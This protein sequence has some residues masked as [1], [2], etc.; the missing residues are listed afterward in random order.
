MRPIDSIASI[1]GTSNRA[2]KFRLALFS[3]LR[4]G[5]WNRRRA[6]KG[7]WVRGKDR[8]M[9]SQKLRRTRLEI[10]DSFTSRPSIIRFLFAL[11]LKQTGSSIGTVNRMMV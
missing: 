5:R 11:N 6:V 10:D 3:C 9:I 7:L 1:K 2:G 8:G 4:T